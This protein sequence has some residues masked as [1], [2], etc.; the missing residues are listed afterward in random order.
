MRFLKSWPFLIR[1]QQPLIFLS[2]SNQKEESFRLISCQKKFI[3]LEIIFFHD[4][5][6]SYFS[7][8][9]DWMCSRKEASLGSQ[10]KLNSV[11]NRFF[12]E[13]Q[14]LLLIF[15]NDER[16]YIA[17]STFGFYQGGILDVK[18]SNFQIDP[19]QRKGIV[20]LHYNLFPWR[21]INKSVL[22]FQF[23]LSLDKTT[24]DVMNPYL[25]SHQ[26]TCILEEPKNSQSRS[27]PI[28]FFMMDLKNLQ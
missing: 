25:D 14:K 1:R 5:P 16:R 12:P 26:D 21:A 27:G 24:T 11:L 20:S 4:A 6:E 2:L 22:F 19:G 8:T 17:L 3:F 28:V 15:Q 10:G 9:C 7:D 18:L 13:F 23:G